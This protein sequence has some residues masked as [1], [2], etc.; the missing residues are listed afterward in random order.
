MV[1]CLDDDVCCILPFALRLVMFCHLS[2]EDAVRGSLV[3]CTPCSHTGKRWISQD[4]SM[5]NFPILLRHLGRPGSRGYGLDMLKLLESLLT[6]RVCKNV[7]DG[8]GKIN[9]CVD[10]LACSYH[11]CVYIKRA[12]F[13]KFVFRS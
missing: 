4:T 7:L 9:T 3:G 13:K 10:A 1:K 2:L 8:T 6:C 12:S 5:S 11:N